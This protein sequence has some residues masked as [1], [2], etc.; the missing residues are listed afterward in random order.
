[1]EYRLRDKQGICHWVIEKCLVTRD[2]AGKVTRIIGCTVDIT[3]RKRAEEELHRRT[4]EVEQLNIRLRRAMQETHHRVKNNLQI[5]VALTDISLNENPQAI[6]TK[7]MRRIG[8]NARTLAAIHDI[9]TQNAKLNAEM[10]TVSTREVFDKL[11][12][13][14]AATLGT[15]TIEYQTDDVVLPV[16][17]GESLALLVS[18]LIANSVKHGTG[19]ITVILQRD[20]EQDTE[21]GGEG[22]RGTEGEREQGNAEE[23]RRRRGEEENASSLIP[24]P[25]SLPN[26]P[27]TQQPTDPASLTLTVQDEGKGFPPHFDPASDANMGMDLIKSLAVYDLRGKLEFSNLPQGGARVQVVFPVSPHPGESTG[28]TDGSATPTADKSPAPTP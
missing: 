17:Q 10:D 6:P 9:L 7:D 27:M 16:L 14:I 12:P 26:A 11:I 22:D 15:R 24:H 25:S 28:Q 23:E 1:L 13:L 3:E 18:E 2:N 20:R 21:R 8:Y 5:I 4:A 19:T